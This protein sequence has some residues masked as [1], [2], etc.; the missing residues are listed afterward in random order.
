MGKTYLR[1]LFVF[2]FVMVGLSKVQ[3]QSINNVQVQVDGDDI[4]ISFDLKFK[5]SIQ[6]KYDIEIFSSRDNYATPLA[7]KDGK[8]K[9]VAAVNARLT[10]VVDGAIVFEEFKG[11][12]NFQ[13]VAT[14]VYAPI[15]IDTPSKP[16]KH[17]KGSMVQVKW[18]GG[19]EDEKFSVDLYKNGVKQETLDANNEYGTYSWVMPR[20]QKKGKYKLAIQSDSNSSNRAFSPEFKIKS[21]VPFIVKVLPVLAAG[22][23]AYYFL[24][25][26]GGESVTPPGGGE[27]LPNPPELP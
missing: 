11:D 4:N 18:H 16:S 15:V 2:V 12:V 20:K 22:A 6:E 27:S 24:E 17:K 23:A 3:A 21:K 26:Q 9:D 8:L 13:I 5:S 1:T 25:V 19:I 7:V 14:M 10:Y